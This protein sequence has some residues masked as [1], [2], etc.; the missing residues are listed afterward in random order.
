MVRDPRKVRQNLLKKGFVEVQGA[1]HVFY[2]F[3]PDG[4]LT[5][6]RT[7][8]S[9]NNQDLNNTLLSAMKNQLGFDSMRDFLDLIDCPMSEEDYI[10]ILKGKNLLKD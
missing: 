5:E 6:I 3:T 10:R 4:A 8:M 2:D 1:K 9:R 7:F